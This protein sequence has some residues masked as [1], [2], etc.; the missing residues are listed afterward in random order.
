M[1]FIR[2]FTIP[3]R[4]DVNP[5]NDDIIVVDSSGSVVCGTKD[6]HL[7]FRYTGSWNKTSGV[8]N[9]TDVISTNEGLIV[10]CDINNSILYIYLKLMVIWSSI[11]VPL[12]VIY[13]IRTALLLTKGTTFNMSI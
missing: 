7:R 5:I 3:I 4:C 12:I 10:V 8:V 1:N 13:I 11:Y 9:T 6:A 2:L